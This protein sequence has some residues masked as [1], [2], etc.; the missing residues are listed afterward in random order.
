MNLS[1]RNYFTV[2]ALGMALSSVSH[3][4]Q[5]GKYLTAFY[6]ITTSKSTSSSSL[7]K[8]KGKVMGGAIG[9]PVNDKMSFELMGRYTAFNSN[10]TDLDYSSLGLGTV[11]TS[12]KIS[13]IVLGANLRFTLFKF[14][15]LVAGA[16]YSMV[17]PNYTF[18][19][20]N[21]ALTAALSGISS[22]KSGLGFSYGAGIQIPV[23]PVELVG[24]YLINQIS[25]DVASNEIT[26]GLRLHF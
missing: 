17:N 15:N 13:A 26:G 10:S 24:E 9:F 3:A 19:T 8:I 5:G 23:G 7:D 20:N 14:F 4:G 11:T 2:I 21:A 25:S 16:G 1:K 22:K 18:S 12:S 6:G